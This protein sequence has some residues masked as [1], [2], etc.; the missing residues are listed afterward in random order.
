VFYRLASNT[1]RVHDS[2]AP[3]EDL[4]CRLLDNK[5]KYFLRD[6]LT[7]SGQSKDIKITSQGVACLTTV[8]CILLVFFNFHNA[9]IW[10]CWAVGKYQPTRNR[11]PP[12][13][14]WG[15]FERILSL[16]PS[17]CWQWVAPGHSTRYSGFF[18]FF[19]GYF[20]SPLL[21]C[22]WNCA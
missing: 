1:K 15:R 16:V 4:A 13:F 3:W 11:N 18:A 6:I 9:F 19:Y 8:F 20:W 12:I 2:S 5:S 7:K 14:L 22:G 21:N 17:E 10:R